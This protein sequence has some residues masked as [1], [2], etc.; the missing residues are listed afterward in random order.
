MTGKTRRI[1]MPRTS[2][3]WV[4]SAPMARPSPPGRRT[5]ASL[6]DERP[7]GD[8]TSDPMSEQLTASEANRLF[9][10]DLAPEYDGTERCAFTPGERT[11]LR[12]ALERALGLVGSDPRA[13]DAGG[14]T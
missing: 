2:T 5:S 9:Y 8:L 10:A 6:V 1:P 7:V 14:G 4:C 11:K 12:G 13:L 3:R